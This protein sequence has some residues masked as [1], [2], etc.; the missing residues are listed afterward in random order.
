MTK[1]AAF[2]ILETLLI[3]SE[4]E[5]SKM[6]ECYKSYFLMQNKNI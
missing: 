4:K 1:T 3:F 6:G 5:S 2:L